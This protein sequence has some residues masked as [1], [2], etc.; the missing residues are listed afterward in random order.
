MAVLNQMLDDEIYP[1]YILV[2]FDLYL[3]GKDTNRE[4]DALIKR[5]QQTG[6]NILAN[7][8]MNIT[9]VKT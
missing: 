8:K 9:F 1:K 4:T 7:E 2:E 3:K 5:L 6:Y